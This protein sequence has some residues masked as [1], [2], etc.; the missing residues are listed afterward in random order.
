MTKQNGRTARNTGSLA[1]GRLRL[2]VNRKPD[3]CFRFAVRDPSGPGL[4]KR[5][6]GREPVG[7]AIFRVINGLRRE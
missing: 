4:D 2:V 5:G 7:K 1:A 6:R 3:E